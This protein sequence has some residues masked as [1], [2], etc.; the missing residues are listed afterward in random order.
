MNLL[1]AFISLS[2]YSGKKYLLGF[3]CSI[4]TCYVNPTPR[5]FAFCTS[6]LA[7][8]HKYQRIYMLPLGC[9]CCHNSCAPLRLNACRRACLSP[10]LFRRSD[11][12]RTTV[13]FLYLLP[14]SHPG[15]FE[16]RSRRARL[17]RVL[18]GTNSRKFKQ[19]YEH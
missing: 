15:V 17:K 5:R 1:Y 8:L 6:L 2:S 11:A 13:G 19:K 10:E 16:E 3:L 12:G 18:G 7:S 9:R 4:K 14:G